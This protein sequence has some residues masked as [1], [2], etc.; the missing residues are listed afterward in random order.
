VRRIYD[1][2]KRVYREGI[3]HKS[4]NKS[5][6]K[7][8]IEECI[9]AGWAAQMVHLWLT[10]EHGADDQEIPSVHAIRRYRKAN[11]QKGLVVPSNV[12]KDLVG[13][14]SP[15]VDYLGTLFRLIWSLEQRYSKAWE[16]E[17]QFGLPM[18]GTDLAAKS[19]L[20][21]MREW[22]SIAQTIGWLPAEHSIRTVRLEGPAGGPLQIE[23]V[24]TSEDVRVKITEMLIEIAS[25]GDT[26]S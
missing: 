4:V 3:P 1:P 18:P 12:I 7:R 25:M 24:I 5:R 15:R 20:E 11:Y 19:L 21:A 10:R 16:T 6:Y 23:S 2:V 13:D 8:D 9:E 22:R 17:Q 26:S 14:V